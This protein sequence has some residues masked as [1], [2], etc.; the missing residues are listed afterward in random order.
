MPF[1]FHAPVAT[2]SDDLLINW[3]TRHS[4]SLPS[5]P[6]QEMPLRAVLAAASGAGAASGAAAASEQP[7]DGAGRCE[8]CWPLQAYE[9]T[10]GLQAEVTIIP[11][12]RVSPR[13]R[14]RNGC[15]SAVLRG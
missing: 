4:L 8:R 5:R 13:R 3:L 9:V 14:R 11:R 6:K 1:A 7:L 12:C 15:G 10:G 2:G